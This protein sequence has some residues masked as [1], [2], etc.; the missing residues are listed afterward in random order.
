VGLTAGPI[1]GV[2]LARFFSPGDLFLIYAALCVAGAAATLALVRDV[3][4]DV[5]VAKFAPASMLRLVRDG[6]ALVALVGIALY[7]TGYGAFLSTLPAF[8]SQ[9][10]DIG[11][12]GRA[13]F[14]SLFYVAI[15]VSQ[16]VTGRLSRRFGPRVFMT[17]GLA[18]AGAGL[19]AAPRLPFGGILAALTAAGLGLGVFYLASMIF[20]NDAVDES[21]KGTVSGAYYLFWGIGELFGAPILSKAS[22]RFGYAPSITVYACVFLAAAAAVAVILPRTTKG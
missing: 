11:P 3:R 10:R 19:L 15:S 8:L 13:A 18:A 5:G 6:G 14:F 1:T 9:A 21:L 17:C 12:T 4:A 16:L 20:L 22:A 2:A 7:G